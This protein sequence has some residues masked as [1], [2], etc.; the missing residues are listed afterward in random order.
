M[1]ATETTTSVEKRPVLVGR[2]WP[3]KVSQGK[4][5]GTR[6]NRSAQQ[7]SKQQPSDEHSGVSD[8]RATSTRP[9]WWSLSFGAASSASARFAVDTHE[10]APFKKRSPPSKGNLLSGA[11]PQQATPLNSTRGAS[12]ATPRFMTPRFAT[13]RFA[14]W[15][16]AKPWPPTMPVERPAKLPPARTWP[17]PRR[18]P[19][20]RRARANGT[21]VGPR[22]ASPR[23]TSRRAQRS[24]DEQRPLYEAAVHRMEAARVMERV[25]APA[26]LGASAPI[27]AV[28]RLPGSIATN[29]CICGAGAGGSVPGAGGPGSGSTADGALVTGAAASIGLQDVAARALPPPS[30]RG[31]T[32]AGAGAPGHAP[33]ADE[34]KLR[35][36]L[37]PVFD[38]FVSL[39]HAH[40]T[41]T[42]HPREPTKQAHDPLT[43]D[44]PVTRTRA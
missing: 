41:I 28:V 22:Y 40:F 20:P 6:G 44:L 2:L 7:M 8:D 19:S 3:P 25:R 30:F 16:G 43:G 38:A 42:T 37:R 27:R 9:A 14:W 13:P 18:K 11:A 12:T 5:A 17:P 29:N 39:P 35:S 24:I 21:T 4:H 1:D 10:P 26:R 34:A 32:D 36:K 31:A 33:G 23:F 15:A